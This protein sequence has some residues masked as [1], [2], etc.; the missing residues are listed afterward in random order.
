MSKK[1][2]RNILIFCNQILGLYMCHWRAEYKLLG[3]L[4]WEFLIFPKHNLT[5][6]CS[7]KKISGVSGA[8]KCCGKCKNQAGWTKAINYN[9]ETKDCKCINDFDGAPLEIDEEFERRV[10]E[11]CENS[12]NWV[13]DVFPVFRQLG[14]ILLLIN[15]PLLGELHYLF[16]W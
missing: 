14:H 13:S 2:N 11:I 15:Q 8:D 10:W 12:W 5:F 4:G 6:Y 7:K 9:I 3:Q 1:A 16:L